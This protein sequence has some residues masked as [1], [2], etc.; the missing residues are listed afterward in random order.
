MK[1]EYK[2]LS[3]RVLTVAVINEGIGDF[4]VYIDA[5]EVER[6]EDGIQQVAELGTKLDKRLARI[7][8]PHLF[9]KYSW[10]D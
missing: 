5:V 2:A 10:R 8:Y 3:T 4:S 7:L 9:R 1:Y 6:F